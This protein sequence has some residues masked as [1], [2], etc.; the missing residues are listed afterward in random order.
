MAESA[1]P[2]ATYRADYQRVSSGSLVQDK[3]FYVL[4]LLQQDSKARAELAAAPALAAIVKKTAQEMTKQ[5]TMAP[6]ADELKARAQSAARSMTFSDDDIAEARA[7]L[8]RR[9]PQS[10]ALQALVQDHLRPSGTYQR[11]SGRSDA[12]MLGD[13]WGEAARGI[14]HIIGRFALETHI[15]YDDIDSPSYDLNDAGYESMIL[16]ACAAAR[17]AHAAPTALFFEPALDFALR[18]LV[19][20]R[21][22]EAARHEP[23]A[24]GENRGAMEKM[25]HIDWS[26]YPYASLL[27]HGIGPDEPGFAISSESRENSAAAAALYKKKTAPF[28]IVSGGYV[29]PKQT[30]FSEAIEMKRQLMFVYG[31]PE[32]AILVD[33]Q[34]RHTTTNVRNAARILFA[35][36]A[37]ADKPSLS[38]ASKEHIDGIVSQGFAQRCEQVFGYRPAKYGK[39]ISEVAAEFTPSLDSLQIDPRDPMDP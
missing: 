15:H 7:T 27:V 28:I 8:L 31:I 1:A 26:A 22:D 12:E 21:R 36:G 6:A 24:T 10:P 18:L 35:A 14:N 3:N 39:R 4:T 16:D 5:R 23:L 11:L 38:V 13:A 37:P 9:L 30:I 34:A 19:I 20:N 2:P 17:S 29:H 33:P 25:R 32:S